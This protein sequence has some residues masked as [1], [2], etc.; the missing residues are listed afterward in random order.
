MRFT[1]IH[2]HFYQPYRA[3]PWTGA[4]DEESSA[5]PYHD[6]N[7]RVTAECYGPNARARILGPDGETLAEVSNYERLS[8][9]FGP[10]LLSWLEQRAPE[11]YRAILEADRVGRAHF[12]GHGPAIAQMYNHTIAPLDADRDKRTQA[13]WAI[14]DFEFRFGRRPEGIW[15]AETA[16]DVPTLE[17]L[18]DIGI[19]FTV[20]A[21]HQ[22]GMVRRVGGNQW[23]VPDP[24]VDTTRAYKCPLPSGRDVNLFFYD[25]GVAHGAAFGGLLRDGRL[26]AERLAEEEANTKV[27]KS[28]GAETTADQLG[29]AP[30]PSLRHIA[31]DGETFGHHHKFGEMAL[32][33]CLARLQSLGA[34][35]TVYGEYLEQHPP[36][37]EARVAEMTSWSCVHGVERWRADC[38]CNSGAHPGWNQAWRAPLRLAVDWL[39]DRLADVFEERGRSL[40]NDPW[41]ARD[42][43][44]SVIL[45][46]RR[47]NVERFLHEHSAHPLG[48]RQ[49]NEAVDLLEMQ[50]FGLLARSSDAWFFDDVSDLTT[51]QA[52]R[53][54]RRALELCR[55]ADGPDLES[56]F[57]GLLEQAQ[58][59]VA[60]LGSGRDI[61]ERFA[62]RKY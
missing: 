33:T 22:A 11:V 6:W 53:C 52:M 49:Q 62:A 61:F 15:L 47:D 43:Y 46:D 9:D 28:D 54:S 14:R 57:A 39:R 13:I 17:T 3:N 37:F 29:F 5:A 44:I 20:L 40:L 24:G 18:A 12:S 38:G 32:A 58:S 7:E 42:D 26:L 23:Q 4:L 31:L 48:R 27:T 10:T 59:N 2:G 41:Q 55:E 60:E 50:R 8:F 36:E 30:R 1:T 16:V 19:R 21:P 25:G 35:L 51:I 56:E 45:D 34:R